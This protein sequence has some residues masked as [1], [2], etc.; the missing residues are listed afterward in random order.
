MSDNTERQNL[1]AFLQARHWSHK[2]LA[3]TMKWSPTF[4]YGFLGGAWGLT[5]SFRWHFAQTFGFDVA[6]KV[7]GSPN[8]PLT[9][10][11]T[12]LEA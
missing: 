6:A 7:F 12:S 8:R 10:A 3:R 2:D 1:I 11:P 5:D 9:T 4:I